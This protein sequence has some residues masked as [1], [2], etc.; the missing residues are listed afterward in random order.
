MLSPTL[1]NIVINDV[2]H[3]IKPNVNN[4][5]LNN[6]SI[7]YLFY[8]DDLVLMSTNVKEL[9]NAVDCFSKI[10]PCI[11]KLTLNIDNTKIVVFDR[12][13]KISGSSINI[14]DST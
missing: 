2:Q 14:D 13:G 12:T 10:L 1:F 5:T 9:Q 4:S 8:T 3:Y 11:W 6:V 7:P